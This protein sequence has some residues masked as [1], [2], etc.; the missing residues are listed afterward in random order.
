MRV[1]FPS[2][3]LGVA[4]GYFM[5]TEEG[6]RMASK[7]SNKGGEFVGAYVDSMVGLPVSSMIDGINEV[8]RKGD[9]NGNTGHNE[10]GGGEP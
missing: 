10:K 7:F 4:I 3:L 1:N 6:R 9:S 2:T 5:F 8:V